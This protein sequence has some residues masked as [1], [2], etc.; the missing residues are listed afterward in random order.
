MDRD[1]VRI[2][3]RRLGLTQ[4][5]LAEALRVDQSTVSRWER[6]IEEPRP[7]TAGALRDLLMRDDDR[8]AIKRRMQVIRHG[9]TLATFHDERTRL[10]AY[11][12][13]VTER[14]AKVF[15]ID[16]NSYVGFEFP[17]FMRMYS[18]DD[19]WLALKNTSFDS[20][21]VLLARLHF[22]VRG[23]GHITE[24]E[25][26]FE[27]MQFAGFTGEVVSSFSA[28]NINGMSLVKAEVVYADSPEL[29]DTVYSEPEH[30]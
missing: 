1:S 29:L 23:A 11:S 27:N 28:P 5:Q 30:A 13:K 19:A 2:L 3:R 26:V 12:P 22:N 24:Y 17:R 9:L 6:G 7:A 8:R 15:K 16:L 14:Y 25:P 20:G 10:R 4:A 21:A 18:M